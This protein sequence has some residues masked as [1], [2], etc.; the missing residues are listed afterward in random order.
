MPLPQPH[1]SRLA[2]DPVAAIGRFVSERRE[3][4]SSAEAARADALD[5][6]RLHAEALDRII[7]TLFAEAE[8]RHPLGGRTAVL[9]LG[10]YGRQELG[11]GS[12]ID[13]LFLHEPA[14]DALMQGITDAIL[15]PFWDNA[16]EVG[17]ATRTLADCRSVAARDARAFTAMTEARLVCGDPLLHED[18]RTLLDGA[19]AAPGDRRRYIEAKIAEREARLSRFGD[20]GALAQPNVKEGE[21]GL[22]DYQTLVWI[23]RAA[24]GGNLEGALARAVPEEAAR[25][26]LEEAH[27]FLWRVRHALHAIDG[28]RSDRLS[29]ALQEAVATRLGL[30]G[31]ARMS[32]AEQL[33]SSYHAQASALRAECARG[34]ER[35]RRE[36]RPA[37][38]LRRRWLRR[39]LDSDLVRTE[40][41]T[42][43][44]RAG[45]PSAD[46]LR[47][48]QVFAVACRRRLP[49]DVETKQSF[50]CAPAG[51]DAAMRGNPE[52]GRL[53]RGILAD[54]GSLGRTIE[55][56]QECG[57]LVRW[58][59]EMEP[60]IELV[61]H[62]GFHFS[63]AGRHTI[64][65]VAE[66]AHL[67][68]RE[69]RRRFPAPARLLALVER[70]AV[71]AA[72]T[73]FHDVGKG[74][75]GD[76]AAVGATFAAAI[77][78]RLGF[79]ARD[80]EDIAFL[81]R[82]H[83]LMTFLAFRR[84]VR[85][86]AQIERFAQALGSREMLAMLSLITFA[87]VR[88][89]GPH[90][91]SDWKGGLLAE[92][93]ERTL[94]HM[95]G[96]EERRRRTA[97]HL[98]T[99]R[100]CLGKGAGEGELSAFLAT[101]PERY[102]SSTAPETIAAH[103]LLARQIEASAVATAV[104]PVEE[105]GCTEIS[106]VT[107]DAPGLFAKLAGVLSAN[108]ANI[109]GAELFTSAEGIAID[110]LWLTDADGR[111]LA[112]PDRWRR[113][114]EEMEAV[115]SG[116]V[117]VDRIV[118]ERLKRRLLSPGAGR[119]APR[120]VL[121]NDVSA[122]ETVVEV[123][124]DDRRGLLYEIASTFHAL[125]CTIDRARITTHLDRVVDVFYIRGSGGEKIA[126]RGCLEEMRRRLLAALEET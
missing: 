114:R 124:A 56:M 9:A 36:V 118:G 80:V 47:Q 12:D 60:M 29:W 15:Y 4:F 72:A 1:A 87:D 92:L 44:L 97:L 68:G 94:A 21:G 77:G 113:I 93:S 67:A 49:L 54:V 102:R 32:P 91:W 65:A 106:V 61:Q 7:R 45:A 79:S 119:L 123:V 22:R 85:D 90:V 37:S 27:R 41:G 76:H 6:C 14:A 111:P 96:G 51:I 33:M 5:L 26:R 40:Y 100:R 24:Y 63:P 11:Q 10:G 3:W 101:L 104:R 70:P 74:R 31:D 108:G 43:A 8:G 57:L 34:I 23:A 105:R 95:A 59:P 46:P 112:D 122:S 75:G 28:K 17:G 16:Q 69:G 83:L 2:A 66:L 117:P 13:L 84:D 81:V 55:E 58:F 25:S 121:D 98:R 116:K 52:A 125:G 115:V 120:V 110:V 53:W 89:I 19:F 103:L 35:I 86:E 107:R 109:V 48:L 30:A 78:R 64:R 99:V 88:A 71:L 39:R 38:A 73:L 126:G 82:S 42:I 50:A 62:D 20:E 18:L